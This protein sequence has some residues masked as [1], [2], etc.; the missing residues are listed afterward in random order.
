MEETA[1]PVAISLADL[2]E[3]E[4]VKE[5]ESLQSP[6]GVILTLG[7]VAIALFMIGAVVFF[8]V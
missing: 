2:A 5:Q 6:L 1:A 3:S 7:M 4:F 8:A